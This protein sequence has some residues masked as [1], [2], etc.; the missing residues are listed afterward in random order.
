MNSF[1]FPLQ[2]ALDWRHIQLELEEARYK[3]QAAELGAL[4]RLRAEVEASGIRV[5][6]EVRAWDKLGGS[7]LAA[8]DQFRLRLKKERARI[9]DQRTAAARK[10]L[11]QQDK[12]ME[13]RRRYRLL[14]RLRD[15]RL[16]E[17]QSAHD[18]ELESIATESYLARW[19]SH[20][21][22]RPPH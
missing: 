7:D 4:D 15:R 13:A 22:P 19:S 3:Q 14:E 10:V 18:K 21:E 2:K 20:L 16:T 1:R 8:L 17:W 9:A 11:E 5:E 6:I 12:M